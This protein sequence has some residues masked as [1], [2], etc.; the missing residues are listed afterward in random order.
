MV[1]SVLAAA[2]DPAMGTSVPA[3]VPVLVRVEVA[4]IGIGYITLAQ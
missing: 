3:L 4:C 2:M 1:R